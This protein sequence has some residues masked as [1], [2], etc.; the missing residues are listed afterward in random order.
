MYHSIFSEPSFW[1]YALFF[2]SM[3]SFLAV[4][5]LFWQYALFFGS[6]PLSTQQGGY[7][8]AIIII[9]FLG[10]SMP[11][12]LAVCPLFL[13]YALFFETLVLALPCKFHS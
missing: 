4:C 5:P 8:R 2:G 11:S 7:V 9:N 6:M 1:Q 3:P 10:G 13:Q 12:F